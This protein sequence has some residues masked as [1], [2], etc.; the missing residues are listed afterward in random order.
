VRL[1]ERQREARRGVQAPPTRT[2][3]DERR[4]AA[5]AE[6]A[7]GDASNYGQA[8]AQ[9]LADAG[10]RSEA[11][12]AQLADGPTELVVSVGREGKTAG[13]RSSP[14]RR[15]QTAAMTQRLRAP[16]GQAVYR[17][18]KWIAEPP[19]VWIENVLGFR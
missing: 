2:A 12:V 4:R 7:R 19:N 9:V 6:G 10:Y 14:K 5:V 13:R 17:K 1:D 3:V 8:P 11:V 16:A 18:R 15:P